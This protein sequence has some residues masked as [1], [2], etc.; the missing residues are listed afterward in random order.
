PSRPTAV[1]AQS[2]LTVSRPIT[3]S[4][5]SVKN[6]TAASRSRTA[7][8]TF[9]SLMGMAHASAASGRIARRRGGR[10]ALLH[11]HRR[12]ARLG[13]DEQLGGD[14][15]L[16]RSDVADHADGAAALLE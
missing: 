3:A 13:D 2:P 15:L 11:D 14:L 6:V 5:R 4:P 7:I 12:P 10:S 1:S 8:P 9:S 16:H